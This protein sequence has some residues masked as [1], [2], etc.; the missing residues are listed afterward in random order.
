MTRPFIAL[1]ALLMGACA[2]PA[3]PPLVPLGMQPASTSALAPTGTA[4][5]GCTYYR[6]VD[7]RVQ[8]IC[9]D[10]TA[11]DYITGTNVAGDPAHITSTEG[12]GG[13]D[14]GK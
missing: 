1:A 10:R 9:P 6:L 3:G 12:G 8:Q 11:A 13:S 5:A 4:V 7:K 2:I 14:G